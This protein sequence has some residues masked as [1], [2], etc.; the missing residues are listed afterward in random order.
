MD[1]STL[2]GVRLIRR[3]AGM[4]RVSTLTDRQLLEEFTRSRSEDAFALLVRRHGA[5]VLGLC[6]RVLQHEQDAE[7]V[8]Q[9][10]FLIL[11]RKAV[12]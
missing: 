7:D 9:A 3:I 1:R 11:A 5:L 6:G 12:P 8:F 10:T 4:A 2:G